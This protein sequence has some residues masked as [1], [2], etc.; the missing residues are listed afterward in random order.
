MNRSFK[1]LLCSLFT[2]FVCL[3]VPLSAFASTADSAGNVFSFD[4]EGVD[5]G[6]VVS[7]DFMGSAQSFGITRV[8]VSGDFI[9][10]AETV[11][12]TSSDIR[13]SLRTATRNLTVEQTR[14]GRNVT[15]AAETIVWGKNSTAN[16]VYLAAKTI[17]FSGTAKSMRASAETVTIDGTIDGDVEVDAK[18]VSLGSNAVITGKLTVNAAEEPTVASGAQVGEMNYVQTQKDTGSSS[19]MVGKSFATALYW[20]AAWFLFAL[21]LCLVL[22][23]AIDESVKEIRSHPLAMMLTGLVALIATVPAIV[24]LCCTFIGIPIGIVLLLFFAIICLMG[25]PFVG[26]SLGRLTLGNRMHALPASIIGALAIVIL[27]II[28]FIG[29]VVW[30]LAVLYLYGYI[31]RACYARIRRKSNPSHPDESGPQS[32]PYGGQ[33]HIGNQATPTQTA[34]SMSDFS[35]VPPVPPQPASPT[36]PV[37]SDDPPAPPQ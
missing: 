17:T 26:C 3:V 19:D 35:E 10:A 8:D 37:S 20:I 27:S 30:I 24:L 22:R 36:P 31:V 13:G 2:L 15:S 33:S 12:I 25:I 32:N 29:I 18:A 34:V 1:M 14:I 28:P 7:G 16:G 21:L 11:H 5:G 6:Q 23:G 4:G 9:A